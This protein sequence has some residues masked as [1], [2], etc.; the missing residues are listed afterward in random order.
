LLAEQM[1]ELDYLDEL[2]HESVRQ[3]LKKTSCSLGGKTAGNS[4]C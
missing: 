2:S 1:V 4:A 3:A